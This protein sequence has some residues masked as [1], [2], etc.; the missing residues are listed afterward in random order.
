MPSIKGP[1]Y[2]PRGGRR[3]TPH[4]YIWC[5]RVKEGRAFG[6]KQYTGLNC[7]IEVPKTAKCEMNGKPAN[8]L[9]HAFIYT[10]VRTVRYRR[11][12]RKL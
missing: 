9:Q 11:Q 6:E 7:A 10:N 3:Q 5:Y 2:G 12:G 4:A 8:C 1:V